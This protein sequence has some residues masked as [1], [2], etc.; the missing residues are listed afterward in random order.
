[1]WFYTLVSLVKI[2]IKHEEI[3]GRDKQNFYQAGQAN[4]SDTS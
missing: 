4:N 1:M 2:I 3:V